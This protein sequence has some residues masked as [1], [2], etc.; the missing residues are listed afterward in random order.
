MV[1]AI[2]LLFIV[3]FMYIASFILY[4]SMGFSTH[5]WSLVILLVDILLFLYFPLILEELK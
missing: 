3:S 4:E 5:E 2:H 1:L